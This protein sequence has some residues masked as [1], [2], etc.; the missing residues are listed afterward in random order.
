ML[1]DKAV[2]KTKILNEII[3]NAKGLPLE[4]QK[5]L[6]AIAKEILS[7]SERQISLKQAKLSE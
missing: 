6:L 5:I 3:I 4:Q 1:D 7:D 2:S